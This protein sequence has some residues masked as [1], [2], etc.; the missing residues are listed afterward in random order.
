M[1]ALIIV[2]LFYKQPERV[3]GNTFELTS[4][5]PHND[6]NDVFC[7]INAIPKL[8]YVQWYNLAILKRSK[9]DL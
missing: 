9:K 7:F 4:G 3:C 1:T 5:E 6:I 2:N 8:I